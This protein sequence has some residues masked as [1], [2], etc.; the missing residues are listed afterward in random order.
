MRQSKLFRLICFAA[1]LLWSSL[2]SPAQG[3]ADVVVIPNASLKTADGYLFIYN[4]PV[5]SIMIELK[6]KEVTPA[7]NTNVPMFFVDGK[8]VQI[9]TVDIQSFTGTKPAAS[10]EETLE[11]HKVWESDYLGTEYGQKLKVESEKVAI[12]DTKALFWG[13]KRPSSNQDFD[14][15]YY[16]STLFGT[17]LL[18]LCSPVKLSESVADYKNLLTGIMSTIKVSSQPFDILKIA[19]DIKNNSKKETKPPR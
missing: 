6:G 5:S 4:T 7:K 3:K 17:K 12:G 8:L 10:V 16:L 2:A 15:D 14:R 11:A 18:M 19:E 13:F 1:I 9:I